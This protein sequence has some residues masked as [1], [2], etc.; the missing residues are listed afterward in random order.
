[1]IVDTEKK[2]QKNRTR[3]YSKE[4]GEKEGKTGEG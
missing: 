1:M 4:E 3:T 2:N